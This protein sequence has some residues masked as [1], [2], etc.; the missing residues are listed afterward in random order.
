MHVTGGVIIRIK[1][2][3]VLGDFGAITRAE[4]FEDKRFKK[5]CRMGEMPFCRTHVGHRLDD[6]VFRFETSAQTVGEVS[7]L[8][9]TSKKAL[10]T[11]RTRMKIWPFGRDRVGCGFSGN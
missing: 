9:K 4:L 8:M 11:P 6:I 2:I 10:N 5:P 3:S 7:G 1:E